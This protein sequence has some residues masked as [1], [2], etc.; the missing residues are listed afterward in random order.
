MK[1]ELQDRLTQRGERQLSAAQDGHSQPGEEKSF[2]SLPQRERTIIGGDSQQVVPSLCDLRLEQTELNR[3]L[4]AEQQL[5]S[6]LVRAV[7]EQDR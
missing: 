6:N 5:D 7:K 1:Q 2:R 3:V 4:R